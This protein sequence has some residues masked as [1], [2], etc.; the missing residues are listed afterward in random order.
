MMKWNL[1]RLSTLKRTRLKYFM[2]LSKH[3]WSILKLR[4][5]EREKR[6]KIQ[7]KKRRAV[8]KVVRKRR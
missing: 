4:K 1:S 8:R 7:R 2:R 6:R 3:I 5:N